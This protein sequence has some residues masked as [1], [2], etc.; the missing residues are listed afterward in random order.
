MLIGGSSTNHQVEI[1][2]SGIDRKGEIH[3][4]S[5][6]AFNAG[7]DSQAVGVYR[8]ETAS[9]YEGRTR[10]FFFFFK[11]CVYSRKKDFIGFMLMLG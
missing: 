6:L 7:F 5:D 8:L 10:V 9:L 2:S 11:S 4:L 3:F 1:S